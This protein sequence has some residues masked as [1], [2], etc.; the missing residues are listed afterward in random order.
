VLHAA[1][2]T[3][4][5][6][7]VKLLLDHGAD[8]DAKTTDGKTPFQLYRAAYLAGAGGDAGTRERGEATFH[9][10]GDKD[11]AV[12]VRFVHD[13]SILKFLKDA[14]T[15]KHADR[16]SGKKTEAE[17]A[18]NEQLMLAVIASTPG[19]R[20]GSPEANGRE[21]GLLNPAEVGNLQN[22]FAK[23]RRDRAEFR[24]S[25]QMREVVFQLDLAIWLAEVAYGRGDPK[26]AEVV[27]SAQRIRRGDDK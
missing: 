18:D 16:E 1:C 15:A 11:L 19:Y 8:P 27:N 17:I 3:Y 5:P 23:D 24:A 25:A 20:R 4:Q 10:L 21:T 7:L 14:A 12:H 22:R 26:F 9:G 6:T 13:I 2:E